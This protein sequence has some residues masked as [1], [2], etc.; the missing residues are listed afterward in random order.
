[1]TDIV[2]DTR[3][4]LGENINGNNITARLLDEVERLR[5]IEQRAQE[6]HDSDIWIN[7]TDAARWILTGDE[8]S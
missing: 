2:K 4:A 3:H 8:P 1:M 6:A 7:G 5:L